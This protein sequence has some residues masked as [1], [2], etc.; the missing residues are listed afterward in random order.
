MDLGRWEQ[1][2]DNIHLKALV[3]PNGI[4]ARYQGKAYDGT[5]GVGAFMRQIRWHRRSKKLKLLSFCPN[6]DIRIKAFFV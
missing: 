2:A 4:S 6:R 3:M 5:C 1:R